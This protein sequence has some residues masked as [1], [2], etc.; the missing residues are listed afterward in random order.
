[1]NQGVTVTIGG[2]AASLVSIVSAGEIR[3]STPP[4]ASTGAVDVTVSNGGGSATL[5]NG[6]T[7]VSNPYEIQ[8]VA[9][10]AR[11][12][13]TFRIR[14]S[15]PPNAENGLAGSSG[16]GPLVPRPA[17]HP[18][19]SMDLGPTPDYSVQIFAKSF[20]GGTAPNLNAYGYADVQGTIPA[21]LEPLSHYYWQAA[22]VGAT[23]TKS[24]QMVISLG[25]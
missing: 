15:G 24:N 7:Y 13:G 14:V 23:L 21:S 12:G 3:V 25:Q 1:L 5:S 2:A 4:R 19:F 18:E 6:F 8:F 20:G 17:T 16:P 10:D 22:Y 9:I 11:P